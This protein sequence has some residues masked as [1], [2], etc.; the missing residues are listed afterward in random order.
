M[1]IGALGHRAWPAAVGMIGML[2][3]LLTLREGGSVL[4]G[5][6]AARLDAGN[7]VAFVVWFNFLAG[8]AYVVAGAA[9]V[10]RKRWAV[11]AA[12][13]IAVATLVV[14]AAFGVYVLNGGAFEMRTVIAMT[15][16]AVVWL[17]IGAAGWRTLGTPSH[18][19]ATT[20]E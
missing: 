11:R 2:F 9:L 15:L 17:V 10:M 13:A 3:G 16:R 14:F 20:T 6:D 1:E 7:Y 4:F 5:G 8:F 12:L 18:L 19:L